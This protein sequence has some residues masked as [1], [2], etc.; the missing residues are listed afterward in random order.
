MQLISCTQHP[1]YYSTVSFSPHLRHT[2]YS[3]K[4]SLLNSTTM[5]SFFS[6]K[7]NKTLS[8]NFNVKF[9]LVTVLFSFHHMIFASRITF[10]GQ[11]GEIS[12]EIAT[13]VL[14]DS[15][16]YTWLWNLPNNAR[17]FIITTFV[18]CLV[19]YHSPL[20]LR[21]SKWLFLFCAWRK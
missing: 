6:S 20:S 15:F 10:L 21:S 8:S 2:M 13:T 18:Y 3:T 17:W 16:V 12:C 9:F 11:I 1:N 7:T 5:S 4:I 19:A 14:S